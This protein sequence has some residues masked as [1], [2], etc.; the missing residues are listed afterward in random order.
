MYITSRA[1]TL[2][3]AM[4]ECGYMSSKN[5]V[6]QGFEILRSLFLNFHVK[7][8]NSVEFRLKH[9]ESGI[10]LTGFRS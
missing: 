8:L 7:A 4:T 10:I 3:R 5:G 9:S 1:E 2:F 6:I